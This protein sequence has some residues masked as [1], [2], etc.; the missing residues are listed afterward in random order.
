MNY[1]LDSS[2]NLGINMAET[3]VKENVHIFCKRE[4]DWGFCEFMPLQRLEDPLAGYINEGTIT[5][6]VFIELQ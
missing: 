2:T 4:K 5:L 1:K 3:V 6:G